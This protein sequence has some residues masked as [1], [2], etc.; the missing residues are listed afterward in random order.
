MLRRTQAFALALPLLATLSMTGCS[1][2]P[3]VEREAKERTRMEA[4]ADQFDSIGTLRYNKL[5]GERAFYQ[6]CRTCHG[7]DGMRID[8]GTPGHPKYLAQSA[9]LDLL[10]FFRIVNFGSGR[11]GGFFN[12]IALQD[13][14]DL[15]G[16]SM[17]L[18]TERAAP[19]QQKKS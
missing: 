11:M 3:V 15:T 8:F 10:R 4:F 12:D 19:P 7:D 16:Y 2:A 5:S 1:R 17:T 9:R 14:V 13:L 6:H 18:P